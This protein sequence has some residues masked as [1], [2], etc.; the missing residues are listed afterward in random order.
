MAK[1]LDNEMRRYILT[2]LSTRKNVTFNALFNKEFYSSSQFAYHLNWLIA[3]NYVSKQSGKYSLGPEG[4]KLITY[5]SLGVEIK[6]P[7]IVIGLILKNKD[8]ILISRSKK[9]PLNNLWGLSCFGK[10]KDV[11]ELAKEKTGYEL[12]K[13]K[14]HGI[15]DVTTTD[16]EL[17]HILLVYFS[18]DFKGMLKS[19]P[20]RE[21]KWV[22]KAQLKK[23]KQFPENEF[24]I[25][26][27]GNH[28]IE[29][30]ISENSYS[31]K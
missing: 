16:L 31:T 18:S 19:E 6:Q 17:H 20:L 5:V 29:R 24:I 26:T 10:Y 27:P 15:Y 21:C 8:K 12:I 2:E 4:K 25:D 11:K 23:L 22:T 13:Y 3:R 9:E 1:P 14:F 7:L 30:N 28:I